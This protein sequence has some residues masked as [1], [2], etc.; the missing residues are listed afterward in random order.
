MRLLVLAGALALAGCGAVR[1]PADPA[2]TARI[3]QVC[4]ASGLFTS[5]NS[6]AAGLVPVPGIALG[7]ALVDAGVDKV[8]ADP[9]RFA[10]DVSTV[11]WLARNLPHA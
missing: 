7:A 11:E 4:L 2:V 6:V 10:G 5:V 9:E 1:Q 3:A 8:C